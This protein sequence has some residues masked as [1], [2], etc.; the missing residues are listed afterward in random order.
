MGAFMITDIDIETAIYTIIGDIPE[1]DEFIVYDFVME[2]D[3]TMDEL[4]TFIFE[5]NEKLNAIEAKAQADAK[6]RQD[7]IAKALAV[8]T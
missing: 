1:L 7:I 8:A 4:Y 5:L 2:N 3:P 6:I